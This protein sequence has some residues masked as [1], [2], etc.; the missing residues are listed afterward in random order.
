[1]SE[2]HTS[3]IDKTKA[4]DAAL[5]NRTQQLIDE[6]NKLMGASSPAAATPSADAVE[7]PNSEPSA[8]TSTDEEDQNLNDSVATLQNLIN[9][10]E[11]KDATADSSSEIETPSAEDT[12]TPVAESDPA[13]A[14]ISVDE[15]V[16]KQEVQEEAASTLEEDVTT[17]SV[18]SESVTS[19]DVTTETAEDVEQVDA[20][21]NEVEVT[22]ESETTNA[23]ETSEV[24]PEVEPEAA[25]NSD[26][27]TISMEALRNIFGDDSSTEEP[28]SVGEDSSHVEEAATRE[29]TATV[30]EFASQIV[31]G[32]TAATSEQ[33][34]SDDAADEEVLMVPESLSNFESAAEPEDSPQTE[35]STSEAE[36]EAE[37]EANAVSDEQDVTQKYLEELRNS[38]ADDSPAET[39]E[40]Q[41]VTESNV[42]TESVESEEPAAIEPESFVEPEAFVEPE[43]V[44]DVVEPEAVTEPEVVAEPESTVDTPEPIAEPT[45]SEPES[46][47]P[48]QRTGEDS[49]AESVE[50]WLASRFGTTDDESE[51]GEETPEE[52]NSD[53]TAAAESTAEEAVED[54]TDDQADSDEFSIDELNSIEAPRGLESSINRKFKKLEKRI[55]G[56]FASLQDQ[57]SQIAHGVGAEGVRVADVTAVYQDGEFVAESDVDADDGETTDDYDDDFEDE[58]VDSLKKRLIEKLRE[59]EIELSISRAKI[60][61][62]RASLEQMKADLERRETALETKLSNAKQNGST[63][64]S[65]A[66]KKRGLMDRWKRHLGE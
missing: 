30:A 56:M 8:E 59:T 48:R 62:E 43:P 5:V 36:A 11:S 40:A 38:F 64:A 22:D 17:E 19:E 3:Q 23:T 51:D 50:N 58:E 45:L 21:T 65:S 28:T 9:G 31:A 39:E 6:V 16:A 66:D 34:G 46:T 1:M 24:E 60:S 14:T 20:P 42:E 7:T 2:D 55:G 63:T 52:Q 12:D 54:N 27:S 57:L 10:L 13:E 4:E 35:A 37:A 26:S 33:A 44:E 61:Q 32:A 18:T 47:S 29:E 53:S 49:A 15:P 25:A 41:Q